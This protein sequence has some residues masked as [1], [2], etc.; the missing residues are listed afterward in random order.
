MQNSEKYVLNE[1]GPHGAGNTDATLNITQLD[2]S[3]AMP[4]LALYHRRVILQ[5]HHSMRHIAPVSGGA[6]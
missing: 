6:T 1:S 5:Y 4:L 3:S 2:R